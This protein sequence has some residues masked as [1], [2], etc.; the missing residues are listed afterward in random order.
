M[1]EGGNMVVSKCTKLYCPGNDAY[2]TIQPND[3]VFPNNE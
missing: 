2:E 3:H 1:P